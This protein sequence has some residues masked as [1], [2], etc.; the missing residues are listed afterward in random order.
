MNN[1]EPNP[2]A[3]PEKDRE[4]E[5]ER[6]REKEQARGHEREMHSRFGLASG[7]TANGRMTIRR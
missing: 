5:R 6:E 4:R 2:E 1:D 7:C 3:D